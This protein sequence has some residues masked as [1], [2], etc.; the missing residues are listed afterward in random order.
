M[1]KTISIIILAMVV[2]LVPATLSAKKQ[3]AEIKFDETSYNFGTI[4]EKG[5]KVTHEFKFTN[6]GD[7]NL[8]ILDAS[9]SCGC[10]VPEFPKAPIA[11]G[12]TGVIKVTYDP[13]YRPGNFIKQIT[14]RSNA[15]NKKA[16]VKITGT[17][18]K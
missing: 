2:M 13:E 4:K 8:V 14:I 15:K 7:A 1:K 16:V 17:V 5:G 3:Q 6:T 10:T 9:A 18:K 11:P 12:K